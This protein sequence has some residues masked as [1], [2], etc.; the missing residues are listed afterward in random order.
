MKRIAFTAPKTAEL[1]DAP[2]FAGPLNPQEL[3][4]RTLVSL[5]S[6]GTELNSGF[7]GKSFP[8]FPGYAAVFAVEEVGEE[9]SD[10]KPGEAVYFAGGHSDFQKAWRSTVVPVPTG[11]S[12]ETAVFARLMAS[13]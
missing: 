13:P 5:V 4:G 3:R 9:I 6:P 2:D 11:L 7:L 12:P 10:V 8:S 1:V